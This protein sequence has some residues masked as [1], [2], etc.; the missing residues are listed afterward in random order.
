MM[1]RPY[2]SREWRALRLRVLERDGHQCQIR[3][4]GCT[5][6]ADRVDHI[7][8]WKQGGA[9]LDPSNLQAAC[10]SCNTAKRYAGDRPTEQEPARTSREW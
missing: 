10:R 9:W 8:G 2:D 6:R 5:T 7:I 3:M 1:R 4:A